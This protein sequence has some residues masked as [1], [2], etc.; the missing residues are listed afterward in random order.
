VAEIN[1][2]GLLF[3][4]QTM[5]AGDKFIHLADFVTDRLNPI[6]VKETRQALK[7]RQFIITFMLLLTVAWLISVFGIVWFGPAIEYGAAG[8]VFFVAYFYVIGF[9]SLFVV[10][11][12]SF[13]SM[14]NERDQNTYELLSISTLSPRQIVNGKL[15]SSMVQ[16][17]IYYSAIAPFIAFTSL[18]QGFDLAMVTLFLVMGLLW[19]VFVSMVALMLSTLSSSRQWQAINTIGMIGLLLWQM[20]VAFAISAEAFSGSIPFDSEEF[21]WG[22]GSMLLG[23]GCNFLLAQQ[24]AISRLTFESDNRSSG[25]RIICTLQFWL[26]WGGVWAFA[27]RY[28][29]TAVDEGTIA[30]CAVMSVLHWFVSGLFFSTEPEH[31]SRRVRRDV[32]RLGA[33]RFLFAPWLPGGRRGLLLLTIHLLALAVIG[34]LDAWPA[35]VHDMVTAAT[36]YVFIYVGIGAIVGRLGQMVSPEFRP[37]HARVLTILMGALAMIAP[38]LPAAFGF[39]RWSNAYSLGEVTNPG[40]ILMLISETASVRGAHHSPMVYDILLVLEW[41]AGIVLLI[42]LPAMYKGISELLAWR[43][44]TDSE[45]PMADAE[46]TDA[47]FS[48]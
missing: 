5:S 6:L 27:Y 43:P 10:P 45:S 2:F 47:A 8:R 28:G 35:W 44:V 11:F 12:G 46:G 25:I 31:V 32:S 19:S 7:S 21:W 38:Y 37:A 36:L 33:I 26:L 41:T 40:R 23:V 14:L 30:V 3:P 48:G 34:R 16:V 1:Q 22:L 18:L 39:T 20:G 9:A 15:L 42:N 17:F 4:G 13:R 24:I 29:A